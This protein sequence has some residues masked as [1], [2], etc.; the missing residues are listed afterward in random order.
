M[1]YDDYPGPAN[2]V[3]G[4]SAGDWGDD[5]RGGYYG[6]TYGGYAGMGYGSSSGGEGYGEYGTGIGGYGGTGYYGY[7]QDNS[8][9]ADIGYGNVSRGWPDNS[10]AGG[11]GWNDWRGGYDGYDGFAGGGYDTRYGAGFRQEHGQGYS[12]GMRPGFDRAFDRAFDRG[13]FQ[14]SGANQEPTYPGHFN[15]PEWAVPGPYTGVGPAGY[16]RSDDRICEDVCLRLTRDG[17]LDARG[18]N[19]RV[20][21]GEV[22]LT[23]TAD[24]RQAKIQAENIAADV[25]GAIG[26]MNEL[27]LRRHQGS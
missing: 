5:W 26:V 27:K 3:Y 7:D 18:I 19:V 24:S 25:P 1:A 10:P 6:T 8:Y 4:S 20:E 22:Y 16:R 21:G 23:G 13:R 9:G 12:R 2:D 14:Q 17:Q 11:A 15:L